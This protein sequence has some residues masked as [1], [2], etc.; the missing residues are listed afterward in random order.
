MQSFQQKKYI[1]MCP[2]KIHKKKKSTIKIHTTQ[3]EKE[4][5]LKESIVLGFIET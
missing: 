2:E 3:V 4:A 5:Y 1:K